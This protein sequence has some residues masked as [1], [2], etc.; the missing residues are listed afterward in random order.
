MPMLFCNIAR[1]NSYRGWTAVDQPHGGGNDPEKEEVHNFHPYRDYVYGYVAA[2]RRSIQLKKL[3]AESKD[4]PSVGGVDVI[5][6]APSPQ[7]G[8]YVVGWYRDATVYRR[9]QKYKR[10][11]KWRLYHVRANKGNC[12]LLPPDKRNLFINSAQLQEGGFGRNVWYA[13]SVYGEEICDQVVRLFRNV[14]LFL[15][16][17][18]QIFNR[19]ELEYIADALAPIADAPRGVGSPSRIK[20]ET[21]VVGRDPE[22]Q[23]WVLQRADRL[24]ELCCK[25]APFDKPNGSPYLEIHH[26]HRLADGGSDVPEN[27]VAL[28]P[29]CHREAHYGVRAEEIQNELREVALNRMT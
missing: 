2:P 10:G 1:M 24:C 22:V 18:R 25:P 6:T 26:I 16:T 3:D 27:A 17:N 28:C 19:D 8:R 7:S 11:R 9:L 20:R 14:D 4:E 21:T 23:R 29:N 13:K 5:W 15:S 12:V